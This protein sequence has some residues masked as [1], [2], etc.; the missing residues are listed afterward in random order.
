MINL[1]TKP[2]P[3]SSPELE[4]LGC[5]PTLILTGY[6]CECG[7][8]WDYLPVTEEHSADPVTCPAC[9]CVEADPRHDFEGARIIQQALRC[10]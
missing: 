1:V 10:G 7:H 5:L 3:L 9:G 2:E 4:D 8:R 6:A